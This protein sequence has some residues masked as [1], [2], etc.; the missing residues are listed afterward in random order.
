MDSSDRLLDLGCGQSI[1]TFVAE[2]KENIW[3]DLSAELVEEARKMN[4]GEPS[5]R[6]RC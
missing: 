3:G 2:N 4:K 5:L 6:G 1:S